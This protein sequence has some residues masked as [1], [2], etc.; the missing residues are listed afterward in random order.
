MHWPSHYPSECPPSDACSA[1]GR[2]FRLTQRRIPKVKDFYSQYSIEK[3]RVELKKKS[4]IE[5]SFETCM[6]RGLSVFSS[7]EECAKARQKIASLR[8]KEGVVGI[9]ANPLQD[10]VVK[11]TPGPSS[12]HHYTWWVP[13]KVDLVSKCVCYK[14]ELD[15]EEESY[16]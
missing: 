15:R 16:V 11:N 5:E 8:K 9:D 4:H 7:V 10:G 14:E 1:D 2:F 13:E 3:K 12:K 6:A